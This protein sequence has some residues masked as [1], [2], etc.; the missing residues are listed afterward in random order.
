MIMG[1]EHWMKVLSL[2]RWRLA[3]M[4]NFAQQFDQFDAGP[5]E[6][7]FMLVSTATVLVDN[8]KFKLLRLI[9]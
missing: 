6:R 5:T 7:A 1:E 2:F 8:L 4:Q 3:N 9:N